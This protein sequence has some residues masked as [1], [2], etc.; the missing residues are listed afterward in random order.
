MGLG[1]A[2]KERDTRMK[3]YQIE[4]QRVGVGMGA[5]FWG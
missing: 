4:F 3:S 2:G 5:E 1:E